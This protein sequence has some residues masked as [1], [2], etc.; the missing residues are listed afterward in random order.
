MDSLFN[1]PILDHLDRIEKMSRDAGDAIMEIYKKTIDVSYKSDHSP[2]TEADLSANRIIVSA[3]KKDYPEIPILTE[4]AVGDFKGSNE[5]GYFWLVD[6]LD[7]TKE[8]I[9]RNGEFTVNIALIFKGDPILGVVFAPE[10]KILY[11][12]ALNHG[13]F[14]RDGGGAL[15]KIHVMPHEAGST[16][17]VAGSRS[18]SDEATKAWLQDLGDH[19]M[20]P[21]GSSLKMCIIAEGL[22]HVYP[23]LGPTSLWDT[24]AAHVILKEAGGDIKDLKGKTL[25][26]ADP[27]QV[28]NPFF[29]A[30]S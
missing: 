1:A 20:I 9:K 25:S 14:K 2:L 15:K 19:T 27:S 8:F 30:S 11:R 12:A 5:E 10:K 21:M 26:Y 13:A 18:H 22:A 7:G 4:E 3:L 6:P 28:L 17:I 29:I 16:W 23:R 24:A